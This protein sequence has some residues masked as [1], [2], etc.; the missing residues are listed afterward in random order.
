M[1]EAG[2]YLNP[3]FNYEPR[4]NKPPLSY[5]A[6]AASY[7]TFGVSLAAA[8]LPIV[9]GALVMLATIFALGRIAYSTRAG[10]IAALTLA[11]TPRFLLFS[12]RIIIDVYIAM[13]LGLTLLCFVLAETQPHRR[14]RWLFA[15]YVATGL[16]V[17]TKGP[18][19]IAL[20]ALVFVVY[21]VAS[22]RFGTI[23]RMM[24]PTGFVLVAAI[25]V[26]YYALLYQQHGW[27]AIVSFLLRENLA[28][29]A[30]GLGVGQVR[31]PLFYLPVLFVDLYFPWSLLLPAG[32][33]LVPWRRLWRSGVGQPGDRG[34]GVPVSQ[35]SVRLLMGLWIILIVAFFSFSKGQQDLYI[36]PCIAAA[37]VLVGGVLDGLFGNGL[38][39]RLRA[40]TTWSVG[41][42][43]IVMLVLGGVIVLVADGA[44]DPLHLVGAKAI[45]I[46]LCAGA[47]VA[48][49][50]LFRHS[51]STACVAIGSAL[52]VAHWVLVSWS[53]PDFERFKP[54]PHLAQAIE[55]V[56]VPGARVGMFRRVSTP[57]VVF[58]LRRRVDHVF[59]EEA[60]AAY[61][62]DPS[63]T[64]CVMRQ[65]EYER[66]QPLIGAPSFVLATAPY[67]DAQ[68]RDLLDRRPLPNMIVVTNRQP[69]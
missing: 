53:M 25:V 13:F 40:A 14:R 23:T 50:G 29:Y 59:D 3:T 27:D 60:L 65:E 28:R 10:L 35:E 45:G 24:L 5:W 11:A 47:L 42:V 56:A 17:L 37:A 21:L 43:G 20:P 69:R 15:M 22:R 4:V 9:L 62:K 30:E 31:G 61:F 7:Q 34:V 8:R 2:D 33:A 16:G 18:I 58:Y 66:V 38:P 44:F 12:R 32:L 68:L 36:L 51:A 26:P 19:A 41:L 49:V 52:V 55:Q 39:A 63:P 54:V 57:S 46:V 48:L 64:Y 1:M 6:V 67:V